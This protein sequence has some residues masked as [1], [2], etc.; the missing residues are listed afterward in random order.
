M[1]HAVDLPSSSTSLGVIVSPT[2]IEAL[3]KGIRDDL[4]RFGH[5]FF[6]WVLVSAFVVAIGVALEGPE[7]LHEMWPRL[8]T[9]FTRDSIPRLRKFKRIVKKV[10][11]WGWLLVVVGVAGEGIF[12]ALQNRAEGQLQTFND[13]LLADAQRNAGSA[14]ASAIDAANAA[15][16]ADSE[17]ENATAASANAMVFAQGARKEAAS[18]VADAAQLKS[19]LATVNFQLES[20]HKHLLVLAQSVRLAANPRHVF[21]AEGM[22]GERGARREVLLAELKKYSG[23]SVLI[24]SVADPSDNEARDLAENICTVLENDKVGWTAKVVDPDKPLISFSMPSGGVE[25][26]TV[27]QWP[28]SSS[29][30]LP[31]VDWFSL[32]SE[33][34]RAAMVLA[35]YLKL[36]LSPPPG[37]TWNGGVG[38][39]EDFRGQL[40]MERGQSVLESNGFIW[41]KKTVLI[42]VGRKPE[43]FVNME[44]TGEK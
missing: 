21:L 26:M 19:D 39:E 25:M 44:F 9:C 37:I 40:W 36:D 24:Q 3:D 27:E 6:V 41:P 23:I 18:A 16:R 22:G 31:N 17:S 20:A 34:G 29:G 12:E 28:W 32:H 43:M 38:Y 4:Q 2:I 30:T 15:S 1:V 35:E 10:G 13:I 33:A 42:L 14:R 7:L 8:F 5:S 11:F